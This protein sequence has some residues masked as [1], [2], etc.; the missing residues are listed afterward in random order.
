MPRQS[1]STRKK[2]KRE[3]GKKKREKSLR[4]KLMVL[5]NLILEFSFFRSPPSVLRTV[6]NYSELN[7]WVGAN[8][9]GVEASASKVSTASSD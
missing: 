5:S 6:S 7:P 2:R 9:S 1:Q 4:N 8:L 3:D